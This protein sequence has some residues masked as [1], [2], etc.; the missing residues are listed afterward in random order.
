MPRSLRIAICT[1][2]VA[3]CAVSTAS[4]V[5]R[6]GGPGNDTLNGTK[7][8]DTLLGRGGNDLLRGRAGNDRL[9]GGPGAD[10]LN[11]G[12]GQDVLA[13][14]AG[15]DR[16]N[17]GPGGDTLLGGAGPDIISARDGTVDTIVCGQGR[18]RVIADFGDQVAGDCE[19]IVRG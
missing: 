1:A 4:A 10:R 14:D 12:P 8:A 16:L 9:Q 6:S 2:L 11:G 13:G 5:M 7:R 17:G 19:R 18:D 3:L 15:G